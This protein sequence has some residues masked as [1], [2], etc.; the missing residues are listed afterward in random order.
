MTM[1][2]ETRSHVLRCLQKGV[3][4]DGRQATQYR[5]ITIETGVSMNAEGSC[6][7]VMGNTQVIVGVK[8]AIERPYPDRPDEGNIMVNVELLPLS[9]PDFEP[10]PPGIFAVEL[11]RVVDRGIREAHA[12][13]VHKLVIERAEKAWSVNIDICT[14]ND[15][16]GLI[17][18]SALAAL[19]AIKDAVFP[20]YSDGKLDY[21]TKTHQ[22]LPIIVQPLA[23]TV[24]KIG[25]SLLVDPCPDEERV[26]DARLT[27][28]TTEHGKVCSLQ[29][30][31][32]TPLSI[33]ELDTMVGIA[34]EKGKELRK[35]LTP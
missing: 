16:G 5:P 15:D 22:R 12:I 1:N 21:K 13:D 35:Y 34:L 14:L 6:R 33:T 10:G 28:T 29:K 3:R 27:V 26:M 25:S 17:D 30:G 7:V 18:A 8:L 9:N 19:A 31:G 20:L 2:E 4:Y 23:V 24:Y 32:D 11:A